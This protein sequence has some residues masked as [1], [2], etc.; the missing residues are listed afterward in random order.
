MK[1][2]FT[3]QNYEMDHKGILQKLSVLGGAKGRKLLLLTAVLAI[4]A[5]SMT[6]GMVMGKKGT[7]SSADSA[8]QSSDENSDS[9]SDSNEI[10]YDPYDKATAGNEDPART[11]HPGHL[12]AKAGHEAPAEHPKPVD[13]SEH[14]ENGEAADPA[15]TSG[16]ASEPAR[17]KTA[18]TAPPRHDGHL[19]HDGHAHPVVES[20]N[21]PV[22][23][24]NGAAR[25]EKVLS[26]E[27]SGT[28]AAE[29]HAERAAPHAAEEETPAENSE[30]VRSGEHLASAKRVHRAREAA[31]PAHLA[32]PVASAATFWH[33]DF[34]SELLGRYGGLFQSIQSKVERLQQADEENTRLKAEN[35]HLRVALESLHYEQYAARAAQT[36]LDFSRKLVAQTGAQSG[37]TLASIPYRVPQELMPNQLYE[38]GMHYFRDHK[39]DQPAD[40]SDEK[41]AVIFTFLLGL[42]GEEGFKTSANMLKAGICWYRLENYEVAEFYFNEAVKDGNLPVGEGPSRSELISQVRLWKALIAKRTGKTEKA[43]YWLREVLDYNPHA[44]EAA[45]VNHHTEEVEREP[46]A[47]HP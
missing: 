45:W 9:D 30:P 12:D 41:A 15:T 46:A 6:L 2:A 5:T 4:A 13:H 3:D 37:R 28:P 22:A 43:Q 18:A 29:A 42:D 19:K 27:I 11:H 1:G 36:T 8:Q 16:K 14:A 24:G 10:K 7:E 35:A 25:E 38:L 17:E 31:H 20:E 34:F 33:S 23:S 44:K 26:E 47:H 21:M 39:P 40:N 32:H